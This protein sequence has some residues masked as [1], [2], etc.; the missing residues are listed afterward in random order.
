MRC[1]MFFSSE[2]SKIM[3]YIYKA[4][5]IESLR[6]T[7]YN[8]KAQIDFKTFQ[9]FKKW[10]DL[11]RKACH[12]CGVKEAVLQQLV[13]LEKLTS[14]R[15]PK[16]GRWLEIDRM[17]PN[18]NYSAD[19]CVLAC[20]FCNNDKSDVFDEKQY[21]EFFQNRA[22]YLKGL[23]IIFIVF[24]SGLG[25]AQTHITTDTTWSEDQFLSQTV[26]IEE[27]VELTIEEGVKIDIYF[28]DAN[29]DGVGDVELIVNGKLSIL[30][31][32][33][34]MVEFMPYNSSSNSNWSG[35]TFNSTEK[36]ERL[37]YFKIS[38]A[39]KGISI[40]SPIS[41]NYVDIL[42]CYNSGIEVQNADDVSVRNTFVSD[43]LENG[44]SITNST[45][46]SIE[47]TKIY[48]GGNYGILVTNSE[49]NINK[50][51]V[52][53]SNST[54]IF[55]SNSDVI[56]EDGIVNQ[57][58]MFGLINNQGD[59]TLNNVEITNNVMGGAYLGGS[60]SS[61]INKCTFNNN[62]G[63][64]I[65]VSE[66]LIGGSNNQIT[67]SN[68]SAPANITINE[69]NLLDLSTY[70]TGLVV[71]DVIFNAPS[72]NY[73]ITLS[74][75]AHSFSTPLLGLTGISFK[76]NNQGGIHYTKHVEISDPNNNTLG[77]TCYFS[78]SSY[79]WPAANQGDC[80]QRQIGLAKNSFDSFTLT[81]S[82][83]YWWYNHRGWTN[84][85]GP[86]SGPGN[87]TANFSEDFTSYEL[88]GSHISSAVNSNNNYD[89]TGNYWGGVPLINDVNGANFNYADLTINE[90]L[91]A[92]SSISDSTYRSIELLS[93]KETSVVCYS[94]DTLILSAPLS[95]SN[96]TSYSWYY[97][98]TNINIDT[99]AYQ[100]TSPGKYSVL[101]VDT[102]SNCSFHTDIIDVVMSS[103][104]P[105]E[106][107]LIYDGNLNGCSGDSIF[108]YSNY[109]PSIE[110]QW[111]KNGS[112]IYE[113][114][115]S[116]YTITS[117]GSYNLIITEE[118]TQC[119][120]S[121]DT[122][123]VE[124]M[125]YPLVNISSV[126]LPI[127]CSEQ[128]ELIATY[129]GGDNIYY[130]WYKDSTLL[131]LDSSSSN[132]FAGTTGIYFVEI[133]N[134]NGCSTF[135]DNILIES[136]S[137]SIVPD[138]NYI[139][140]ILCEGDSLILSVND[141]YSSY[142]WNTGQTDNSIVVESSG[143]YSLSVTDN[144]GCNLSSDEVEISVLS[145][146]I[147]DNIQTICGNDTLLVGSSSYSNSGIYI[148]T[149]IALNGC[150]SIVTT[151]L[152]VSSVFESFNLHNICSNEQIT[153]GNNVYDISGTYVDVLTAA[154][155]CDSV[156]TTIININD[157]FS[158]NLHNICQGETL[159][160][161]NNEYN[162]TGI[163]LDTLLST[164]NC[165]SIISTEVIV[166]P[167][168]SFVNKFNICEGDSIIV[169]NSDYFSEGYYI[170]T[171]SSQFGCD[172][173]I[174]TIIN[175][176][177]RSYAIDTQVSSGEYTWIDGQ[178]YSSPNDSATFILLNSVGCDSIVTL[179]LSISGCTDESACNFNEFA[180]QQ[181][182]CE[183]ATECESCSGERDGTGT[184]ITNDLDSDGVCD[185]DEVVGCMEE[186]ACNY[187][188]FAT[189]SGACNL[190]ETYYDCDGTCLNDNDLDNVCDELEIYGCTDET[191]CNFSNN[192]T[193]DDGTCITPTGCETCVGST[194]VTN[195]LD[196]DGV[197]DADEVVGCMEE[198]ACNYN[199]FATDSGACNLAETYYDCDGTCL[200]DND[201]DNVCDELEI[202][203][204]TDETACNFSNNATEDD[205]SCYSINMEINYI[206][207]II[208][209]TTDAINPTFTWFLEGWN[210]SEFNPNFNHTNQN[211]P[212]N[213]GEYQ[214][215]VTDEYGC[216]IYDLI[217]ID[218][219]SISKLHYDEISI[220]P[221]PTRDK[222]FIRVYST[223]IDFSFE[224]SDILGNIIDNESIEIIK[225]DES[226]F[227]VNI[228][229]LSSGVFFMNSITNNSKMTL[230]FMKL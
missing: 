120:L 161:G 6:R 25:F 194:L 61:N 119:S 145:N 176:L 32:P 77:S 100:V 187:N 179:N 126:G 175:L 224:I 123:E 9:D 83:L 200:N 66:Y 199:E 42:N 35:I 216:E 45:N 167:I 70:N 221:N 2:K 46:V 171:L 163:Y 174:Y 60:S 184:V 130:N 19:N 109:S 162:S 47:N 168:Y 160:V 125:N 75:G 106:T 28:I 92:Y 153:V 74:A 147:A 131:D 154:N 139:N 192:A 4:K 116:T 142:N 122:I 1:S 86:G 190:A 127:F 134:E 67:F 150:D 110:Y 193:E 76:S 99:I 196:S 140:N 78:S 44:L 220:Y 210:M 141:S 152:T 34:S 211:E 230:P 26:I 181:A 133:V 178:V 144:N 102:N 13:T 20:Y 135:S 215:F 57:N 52:S 27:G 12:Y 148:D 201:L 73:N 15:F 88:G 137:N 188:E 164:N 226:K 117:S 165:D 132:Y 198:S 208:T 49:L 156:V 169:G 21:F 151:S 38:G 218:E 41:M 227:E 40:F 3:S 206:N 138:I 16:R 207:N 157:S 59:F 185:A 65:E 55:N 129:E 23:L 115:D 173:I 136:P 158:S 17:K 31:S 94:T 91:S 159:I 186:S 209:T 103:N 48:A 84:C 191:A 37:N 95:Y 219:L 149:L 97:N 85:S 11:Q 170:D 62:S 225:I 93:N 223:N 53:N 205:G 30:G 96:S 63:A 229:Q 213:T 68:N 79:N 146:Q 5:T 50:T 72:C 128:I 89:V 14:K 43:I 222:L 18:E 212:V 197:C 172:S 36:S 217:F 54:G 33:C 90:I 10:Y 64:S 8:K 113:S 107:E 58:G 101:V 69:S 180:N 105:A 71:K 189:D 104:F 143:V 112:L 29:N 81:L 114:V 118:A 82:Q 24:C 182:N 166:H 202:Y 203:G 121:S 39:Y 228:S 214:I 155:G 177:E 98:E 195:D 204:C 183:Y 22:A 80:T 111:Y 87:P 51:I 56:F 124:M 108:V 7:Y